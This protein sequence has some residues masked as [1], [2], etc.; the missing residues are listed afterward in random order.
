MPI[1][2]FGQFLLDRNVINSGVWVAAQLFQKQID[3]PVHALAILKGYLTI[4]QA[5]QMDAAQPVPKN[6]S[7]ETLKA[8]GLLMTRHLEE[9]E[10]IQA[11]EWTLL[12]EA[13]ARLGSVSLAQLHGEVI[14]YHE[15]Q[16]RLHAEPDFTP[17]SIPERE[18]VSAFLKVTLDMFVHYTKQFIS[19]VSVEELHTV[20]PPQ[21]ACVFSQRISG[22]K[23]CLYV[24]A[25]PETL[26]VSL[27][28]FMMQETIEKMDDMVMDAVSE[29]VNVIVGNGCA[30]LSIG[31]VRVSAEMP[32]V[33]PADTLNGLLKGTTI[34]VKLHTTRGDFDV[35]F[36]FNEATGT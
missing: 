29:F 22:A 23:N 3:H 27:A 14:Q 25:L 26:A 9:L 2:T 21:M 30:K 8:S 11:E 20:V 16:R 31:N 24:L 13:L 19:V 10:T 32:R 36:S 35:I 7:R 6:R 15:E 18:L 28:S 34:S 17:P 33:L 1:R 4:D 12:A 5:R